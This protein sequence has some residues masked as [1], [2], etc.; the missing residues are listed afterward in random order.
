MRLRSRV[1][2]TRGRKS[3][4]AESTKARR[5]LMRA[6]SAPV[7]MTSRWTPSNSPVDAGVA[8]AVDAGHEPESGMA[9]GDFTHE[10]SDCF[11]PWKPIQLSEAGVDRGMV[12]SWELKNI[13]N[14]RDRHPGFQE[15][16]VLTDPRKVVM[17]VSRSMLEVH[18][19]DAGTP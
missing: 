5:E 16:L 17:V 11:S 3:C 13:A 18:G 10:F 1:Q 7:E 2:I 14:C 4:W 12:D 9:L 6:L 8:E 15:R 19:G